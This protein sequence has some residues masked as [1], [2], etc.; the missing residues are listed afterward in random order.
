MDPTAG[1]H[2]FVLQGGRSA[3][4]L[5]QISDWQRS[6]TEKWAQPF[7]LRLKKRHS[8]LLVAYLES[9]NY[10]PRALIG[11][12]SIATVGSM[13]PKQ[14]LGMVWSIRDRVPSTIKKAMIG[15]NIP[16]LISVDA[17]FQH[18]QRNLGA[19]ALLICNKSL[20][21]INKFANP[22]AV[23]NRLAFW[24]NPRTNT[25]LMIRNNVRI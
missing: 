23:N 25:C 11:A 1:S 10:A 16:A 21:A 22:P 5:F 24:L 17:D 7:G 18:Q 15:L 20:L 4:W 13:K 12:F 19:L 9:P 3:V 8:A 6:R 14:T 2:F